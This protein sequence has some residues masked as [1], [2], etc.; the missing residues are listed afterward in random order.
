MKLASKV[1]SADGDRPLRRD[2]ASVLADGSC[3]AATATGGAAVTP[4]AACGGGLPVVSRTRGS[5]TTLCVRS[6]PQACTG[7]GLG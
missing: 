5:A 4:D 7:R 2:A 1:G 6:P 3:C